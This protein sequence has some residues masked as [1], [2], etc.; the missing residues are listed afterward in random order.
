MQVYISNLDNIGKD[1][2][3]IHSWREKLSPD[4]L[5]CYESLGRRLRKMQ[6]LVGHCMLHD[7][8]GEYAS[9]SHKDNMVVVVTSNNP[10]GIDIENTDMVRDFSEIS[11]IMGLPH[12]QSAMDFYMN[13]VKYESEFKMGA[14]TAIPNMYYYKFDKY[15]IGIA[16]AVQVQDIDFIDYLTGEHLSPL[17]VSRNNKNDI[18]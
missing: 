13:F 12:P 14:K 18:K 8:A 16:S 17:P 10:V 9:V 6:F 3:N 15:I 2:D 4:E 11:E 5:A 1:I 7:V